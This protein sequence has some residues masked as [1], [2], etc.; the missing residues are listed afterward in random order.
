MYVKDITFEPFGV[1][2]LRSQD[3]PPLSRRFL[4]KCPDIFFRV[5][6]IKRSVNMAGDNTF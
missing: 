2:Y 6:E 1:A 4:Y 5:L 3:P